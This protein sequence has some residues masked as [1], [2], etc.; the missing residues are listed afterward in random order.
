MR[1]ISRA[2]DTELA[3]CF[4]PHGFTL[5]SDIAPRATFFIGAL[6]D[7]VVDIGDVGNK[8]HRQTGPGEVPAKD[9]IDQSGAPM[10]QMGRPVDRRTT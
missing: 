1:N 2:N 10:T 5:L 6:D 7:L 4:K 9:V 8:T 3:H